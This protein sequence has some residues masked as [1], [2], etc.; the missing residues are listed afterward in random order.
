MDKRLRRMA[1]ACVVALALLALATPATAAPA[2]GTSASF[3]LIPMQLLDE[4][5]SWLDGWLDE[6]PLQSIS[7]RG[8]HTMDPDGSPSSDLGD[9]GTVTTQGGAAMDPDG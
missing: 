4:V 3:A 6:P 5:M 8:G 2:R 9:G 1:I 7:A